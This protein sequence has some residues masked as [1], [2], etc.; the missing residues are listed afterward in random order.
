VPGLEKQCVVIDNASGGYI[1]TSYLI[2][3]GHTRIAHI[4]GRTDSLDAAARE[5][6]YRQALIDHGLTPDPA[7]V[8]P[9]DYTEEAG[10]IAIQ[11]LLPLWEQ[12]QFSAIFAANDQTAIGTRLA[13]YQENIAV[14]EAISLVGFDDWLGARYMTPPLTTVRQPAYDMGLI[15]AQAMGSM[16]DGLA[17][18]IPAIPLELIVRQSVASR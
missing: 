17:Y 1:A 3:Q 7:L 11:K 2:S 12:S 16:L 18:T 4:C 9:G 5:Q 15:A 8:V 10:M 13:L 14:P 6:G